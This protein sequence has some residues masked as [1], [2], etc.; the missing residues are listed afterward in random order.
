MAIKNIVMSSGLAP[1][2][3]IPGFVKI[4]EMRQTDNRGWYDFS[5]LYD[6]TKLHEIH[7][8]EFEISFPDPSDTSTGLTPLGKVHDFTGT[9]FYVYYRTEP[10][11]PQ[12]TGTHTRVVTAKLG[13]TPIDIYIPG[14][15]RVDKMRQIDE[16]GTVEL[17]IRMDL[18]KKDQIHHLQVSAKSEEPDLT[19][20]TVE[21]GIVHAPGRY[22]YATYTSEILS[23]T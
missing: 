8:V 22:W 16:W 18:S 2:F 23:A 17:Y 19:A 15:V 4:E 9:S 10:I 11:P 20:G 6:D 12:W 7:R 1:E 14:F 21:L 5:I 13:W 3:W